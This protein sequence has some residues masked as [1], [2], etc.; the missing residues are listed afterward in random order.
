M[1]ELNCSLS[2]NTFHS[3]LFQISTKFTLQSRYKNFSGRWK[4]VPQ[5]HRFLLITVMCVRKIE[6]LFLRGKNPKPVGVPCRFVYD[7][8]VKSVLF[9]FQVF[10]QISKI[11]F[12]HGASHCS[13]RSDNNSFSALL[14]WTGTHLAA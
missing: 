13:C 10:K 2:R 3:G 6:C 8:H 4:V 14:S 5:Q 7:P 12:S 11:F 9:P 1:K